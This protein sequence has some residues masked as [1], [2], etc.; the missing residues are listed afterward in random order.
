MTGI[1]MAVMNSVPQPVFE[2]VTQNLQL[3][4]NAA[5]P[6]SY[7]GSGT[8]WTDLSP[9]AYSTTLVGSPT[10]NSTYFTF[11]GTTEY[12]DTNQSLSSE[13]FSVGAWFRTTASGINMI[14]S[15]ET[16]AGWPWNYRIWLNSGQIIGDV[17]QSGG[18]NTAINSAGPTYNDGAWH[19]VMF[20]RDDST[21]T[22]YVNGSQIASQGD[23]LTGTIVNAQEL[24]IGRSA[25]TAGGASPTGSYQY[26][27]D[28]GQ[29]FIY[30]AVLTPT[31]ILQNYNATRVTYGL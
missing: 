23:T 7:P 25:F 1:M 10:F 18:T 13:S 21:L 5:D 22:L 27:G 9:N 6:A 15:K 30:N 24:W 26:I 19:L 16:T 31:Q 14:L 17:A 20:T 3:Y 11:D 29:I 4:L 8:T 12:V 28:I 2:V